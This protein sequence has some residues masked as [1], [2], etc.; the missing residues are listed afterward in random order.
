MGIGPSSKE[1]T[2]HH[3]RDPLVEYLSND[4]SLD[5]PGIVLEGTPE[6]CDHKQLVAERA[7]IWAETIRADG[8]IVSID[9]WGN[10]HVDF[11][12]V[13]QAIGER[14]IPVVG[15]SFVGNQANFVV[16]NRYMDTI[17]DLNKNTAGI[18]TTVVG[19]NTATEDDARKAVM[20]LKNKILKKSRRENPVIVEEK[21]QKLSIFRFP[22]KEV[23]FG[24][25]CDSEIKGNMLR[26]PRMTPDIEPDNFRIKGIKV[27]IIPPGQHDVPV[28]SILDFSP[29]AVKVDGKL[30]MGVTHELTGM[31][32]MLTAVEEGGFQPAN[33]GS[34]EGILKEKVR[35]GR[36]G[37][38][39]PDD[40]ILHVDIL[41]AEG[42]GRTKEGIMAAHA[43]CDRLVETIRPA[44]KALSPSL[45][46]EHQTCWNILRN[47][48]MRVLLVKLISGLGCLYDTG[49][50]PAQPGGFL[51]CRSIMDISN[52]MQVVMSPNEYRDGMV[53]SLT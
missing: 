8:V 38:P 37:T 25:S 44:L 48:A 35:L 43:I 23:T 10:S 6:V 27:D 16:T 12:S 30:G 2:L 4:K 34:S 33:I 53:H 22:V 45:T 24:S 50:F 28:N 52:N 32:V 42:E 31:R 49:L 36:R 20:I 29:V 13:I 18:E 40:Y 19:E 47:G 7:G 5:F 17:I 39:S 51:K 15:L 3:Y 14:G 9:S 26:I 41:L 46:G 11:T 1:T 21:K